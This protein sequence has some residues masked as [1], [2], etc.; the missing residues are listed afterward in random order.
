M[1]RIIAFVLAAAAAFS[2]CGCAQEKESEGKWISFYYCRED[3]SSYVPDNVLTQELRQI[4][5]EEN[6]LISI[7]NLYLQG[8]RAPELKNVFPPNCRIVSL[9]VEGD[10]AEVC[11]SKEIGE[12]EGMGLTVACACFAK[13]LMEISGTQTLRVRGD[14]ISLAGGEYVEM[15]YAN[16]VF[17]DKSAAAT[18]PTGP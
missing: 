17:D 12:L 7:M 4:P 13:T 15:H 18:E 8:P 5:D 1:K 14:G 11:I 9:T 3:I 2:L 16:L 10:V 6:D